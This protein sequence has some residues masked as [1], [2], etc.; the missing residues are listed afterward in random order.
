MKNKLGLVLALTYVIFAF[1]LLFS[2]P[3]ALYYLL[4][5]WVMLFYFMGYGGIPVS[6]LALILNSLI[7][8]YIGNILHIKLTSKSYEK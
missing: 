7:L 1:I 4:E 8:Y 2:L 5:P 3:E 6:I